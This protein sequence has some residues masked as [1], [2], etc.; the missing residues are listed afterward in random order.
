VQLCILLAEFCLSQF[1]VLKEGSWKE[2]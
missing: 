1:H 2:S